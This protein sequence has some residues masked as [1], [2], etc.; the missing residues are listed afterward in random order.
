V[1][2]NQGTFAFFLNCPYRNIFFIP[3]ISYDLTKIFR[4]LEDQMKHS[5]QL[6]LKRY[7]LQKKLLVEVTILVL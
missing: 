5:D 3:F 6:L 4:D 2:S 1:V 7:C